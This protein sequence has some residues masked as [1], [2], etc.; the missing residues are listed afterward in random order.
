MRA[1][2]EGL[3]PR[4]DELVAGWLEVLLASYPDEARSF[5]GKTADQFRNPVGETLATGVAS[6]VDGLLAG[7]EPAALSGPLEDL[8][9]IRAVQSLS[10]DA[11]LGFVLDLRHVIRRT[12]GPEAL[13]PRMVGEL[14]SLDRWVDTLALLAFDRYLGCRER[15]W[16]IRNRDITARTYSLLKRAGAIDEDDSGSGHG[17]PGRRPVHL[18]GGREA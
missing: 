1:I 5:F 6:L 13:E 17:V 18:K 10:V 4:R 15:V 16:E 2:L 8:V 7:A 3:A 11:A 9:R 14:A 12:L